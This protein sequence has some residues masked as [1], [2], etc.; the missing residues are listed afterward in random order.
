MFA[1]SWIWKK[2]K[3]RKKARRITYLGVCIYILYYSTKVRKLRLIMRKDD[4]LMTNLLRK[5]L[6]FDRL[7]YWPLFIAP[8]G[9]TQISVGLLM[10]IKLFLLNLC[11]IQKPIAYKRS[12]VETDLGNA[13]LDWVKP[14]AGSVQK[15]IVVIFPPLTGRHHEPL[16]KYTVDQLFASN[17][18]AVVYNRRCHENESLYFSVIGD[19]YV[20]EKVLGE[21]AK[22]RP[23]R[24]L[25][26]LGF[27]AGTGAIA[28]Y[29][30]DMAMGKCRNEHDVRFTS[31]ISPGYTS[32]FDAE[33]NVWALG[34]CIPMMNHMFLSAIHDAKAPEVT[35]KLRNCTDLREWIE[36]ASE[37]SGYGTVESWREQCCPGYPWRYIGGATDEELDKMKYFP[38]VVFSARDDIVFPWAVVKKYEHIFRKMHSIALIDTDHGSHCMYLDNQ[39]NNWAV[40]M[41]ITI[42][43]QIAKEKYIFCKERSG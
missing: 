8:G 19:P 5:Q 14:P 30:Q 2:L 13:V 6:Q 11:G 12:V 37:L 22:K 24:G 42:F 16:I 3:T 4:P 20:T 1:L 35:M 34:K 18:E 17:Y 33:A 10:T 28:R 25:F 27:S 39:G 9:W 36:I 43:D 40:N 23:G 29:L 7:R 21:I 38:A 15:P 26:L 32:D 31:M 41:S